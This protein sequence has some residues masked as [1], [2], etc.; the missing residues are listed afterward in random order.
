VP[1]QYKLDFLSYYYNLEAAWNRDVIVT[2]KDHDLAPGAGVVDLELG[3]MT[4]LT[5]YDWITDSTVDAGEAWG[6]IQ[7]TGYKSP[8]SVIHYLIDNVSKNGHLLLN[9]GPKP[10]GTFPFE[11]RTILEEMG[12]W[13]A[14]NGEA[15]YETTP[16]VRYGEGPHQ[17]G[18]SGAFNEKDVPVFTAEDV[19]F[20]VNG[21]NLY[22]I[23]LGWPEKPVTIE[24]LAALWGPEIQSVR[25]LG[26]DE[27]LK[28]RLDEKGLTISPPQQKP[29]RHAV[30]FKIVRGSVF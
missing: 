14:V 11:A 3:R 16:W 22:A 5:Y 24:A 13:L 6:Y 19:R 17:I 9:V 18:K 30:A 8:A 29:C 15:I 26:I 7:D 21:R 23:C 12:E 25:M 1:E 10:D 28:W 4:D 2:Y 27:E 20:T